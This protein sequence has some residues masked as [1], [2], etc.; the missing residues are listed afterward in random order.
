MG[1][2]HLTEAVLPIFQSGSF[3]AFEIP[4][5]CFLGEGYWIHGNQHKAMQTLSEG[6]NK[7]EKS[8]ARFFIGFVCRIMALMYTENDP[9]RAESLFKR[10]INILKKIKAENE[11]AMASA[12][13]GWLCKSRNNVSMANQLFQQAEEIFNRLGTMI[14]RA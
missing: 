5:K 7:A 9:I 8:N 13:Y 6:L 4:L 1:I 11:M 10:S 3:T 2:K 14:D 12:G